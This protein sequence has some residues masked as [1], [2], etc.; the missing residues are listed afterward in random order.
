LLSDSCKIFQAIVKRTLSLD[1]QP[2]VFSSNNPIWAPDSQDKA[3]LHMASNS[4]IYSTIKSPI[5]ASAVSI[6][7]IL[8]YSLY[9]WCDCYSYRV[10]Q[11]AYVIFFIHIPF[12]GGQS[13]S[14]SRSPASAVS[15]CLSGVI[16]TTQAALAVSLTPLR[17]Q[18][19]EPSLHS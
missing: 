13:L 1:F 4:R 12:K 10:V 2:P 15:Y 14:N 19:F 7:L 11:L 6:T 16:A 9:F 8:R 17:P 5:L 18:D 3:F